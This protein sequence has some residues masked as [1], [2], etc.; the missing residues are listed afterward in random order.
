IVDWNTAARWTAKVLAELFNRPLEAG[1]FW[2]VNLPHLSPEEPDPEMV[3]CEPCKCP[4][5]VNYRIENDD[6]YYYGKYTDRDRTPNSDVD[7]CFSGKIAVTQ[8]TL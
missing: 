7:V 2:N 1:S 8:L 4:L 3:F 6:F 5:P